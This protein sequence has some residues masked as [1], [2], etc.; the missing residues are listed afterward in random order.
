MMTIRVVERLER[1]AARKTIDDAR[2][3]FGLN[4]VELSSPPR[5]G[6]PGCMALCRCSEGVGQ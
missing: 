5:R 6:P 4:Y 1:E 2:K 3:K